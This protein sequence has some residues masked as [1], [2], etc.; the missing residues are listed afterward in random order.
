MLRPATEYWGG[1]K[2]DIPFTPTSNIRGQ[3]TPKPRG[4][5][6]IDASHTDGRGLRWGS[7]QQLVGRVELS[8]EKSMRVRLRF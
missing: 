8:C 6:A 7:S 3:L 2:K 1:Q 4:S 5:A